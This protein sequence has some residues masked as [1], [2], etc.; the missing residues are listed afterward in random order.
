MLIAKFLITI[1]ILFAYANYNTLESV[2]IND[3]IEDNVEE[4]ESK[5]IIEDNQ[6]SIDDLK[7]PIITE[8]TPSP[9][10][11]PP[12]SPN[13]TVIN[14]NNIPKDIQHLLDQDIGFVYHNL[15]TNERI[16]YNEKSYFYAASTPKPIIAMLLFDVGLDLSTEVVRQE[17]HVQSGRGTITNYG[18][19]G[20][21]YPLKEVLYEMIVSSDN[22]ATQMAYSIGKP[23]QAS[24]Y[25][26]NYSNS[27]DS[28]K[29]FN[30]ENLVTPEYMADA[31]IYLHFNKDYYQFVLDLMFLAPDQMNLFNNIPEYAKKPGRS[32]V[33]NSHSQIGLIYD[34]NP[35]VFIIYTQNSKTI[36]DM[37][38]IA[39][40]F[41]KKHLA[42][43]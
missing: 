10:V 27:S 9:S 35:F 43:E 4:I 42:S 31:M 33:R 37:Q 41:L 24:K 1:F 6:E 22:T 8:P 18:V 26:K 19:N 34:E 3:S 23:Y 16:S 30:G 15:T 28:S 5:P 21:V 2:T 25:A 13:L 17:R 39:D 29:L 40:S 11:Q 32:S 7:E 12:K 14:S 36:E 38:V 20:Q